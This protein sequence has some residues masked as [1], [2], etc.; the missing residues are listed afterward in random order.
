MFLNRVLHTGLVLVLISAS[1][2]GAQSKTRKIS[3]GTWGGE[4][5]KVAVETNSATIEYSCATGTINGPLVFDSKGKFKFSGTHRVER[6]GPIRSDERSNSRPA[7]YTGVIKGK[8]MTLTV[9]LT[10]TNET[11]GTFKLVLGQE[12]RLFR[13]M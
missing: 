10:D 13:C 2:S 12:A 8:T 11:L 4:Q 7:I 9:K 5:I 1:L 3:N 6:G